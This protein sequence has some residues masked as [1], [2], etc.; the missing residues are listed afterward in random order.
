MSIVTFH[1]VFIWNMWHG[2]LWHTCMI[3]SH[4]YLFLRHKKCIVVVRQS[5]FLV[6]NAYGLA[7]CFETIAPA[8]IRVFFFQIRK[9]N[10]KIW[11]RYIQFRIL[12]IFS[13][14]NKCWLTLCLNGG[15]Y[16]FKLHLSTP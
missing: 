3:F 1:N 7:V 5:I 11:T 2:L 4:D 8:A 9:S 14:V 16:L 15:V 13:N 10:T 6:R 12:D